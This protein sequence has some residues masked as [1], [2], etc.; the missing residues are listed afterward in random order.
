MNELIY[1]HTY[2]MMIEQLKFLKSL[3]SNGNSNEKFID[4]ITMLEKS[5]Y[6]IDKSQK[7]KKED[8]KILDYFGF[9]L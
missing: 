8:Q 9:E 5:T 3:C 1:R 6:I 7:Q 4:Y 2:D